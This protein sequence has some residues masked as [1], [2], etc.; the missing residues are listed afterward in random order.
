MSDPVYIVVT[1]TTD[2][3]IY[4]RKQ[5]KESIEQDLNDPDIRDESRCEV[6]TSIPGNTDPNYWPAEAGTRDRDV[7]LIIKGEVVTP[8]TVTRIIRRELP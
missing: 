6:L 3:D 4:V 7:K 8:E 2:G 1:V 5:T